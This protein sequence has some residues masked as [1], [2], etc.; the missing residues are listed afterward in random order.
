LVGAEMV[1]R[2]EAVGVTKSV[3]DE[4]E[5]LRDFGQATGE[6]APGLWRRR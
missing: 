1:K 2:I 3:L 5:V 4:G 6:A